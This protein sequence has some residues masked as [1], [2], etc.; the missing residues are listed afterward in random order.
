MKHIILSSNSSRTD[1]IKLV[2]FHFFKWTTDLIISIF[3][4]KPEFRESSSNHPHSLLFFVFYYPQSFSLQ[5]SSVI[6][7][8]GFWSKGFSNIFKFLFTAALILTLTSC[9]GFIYFCQFPGSTICL[10]FYRYD[11]N[12]KPNL[13]TSK[14]LKHHSFFQCVFLGLYQLYKDN[15]DFPKGKMYILLLNEH[16]A[17]TFLS[18]ILVL[19]KY[20]S[21]C[22]IQDE[23]HS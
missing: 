19:E 15:T 13:S 9:M 12:L 16:L 6:K 4:V 7:Q 8:L 22:V 11:S 10:Y 20:E 23:F 14:Q 2:S 18:V 1:E 3:L 21:I 5:S 17:F